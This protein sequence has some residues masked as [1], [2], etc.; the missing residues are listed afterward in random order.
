MKSRLLITAAF[1]AAL[2]L[3]G[4]GAGATY[5]SFSETDYRIEGNAANPDGG[6]RPIV[7]YRDGPKMRLETTTSAGAPAVIVFDR[8]AGNAYVLDAVALTAVAAPADAPAPPEAPWAALGAENAERVGDCTIA[9]EDGNEWRAEDQPE[10]NVACITGDGI[11]L[12][13]REG[14]QVIFEATSVQRGA[15]D[16]NLFGVPAGYQVVDPQAVLAEV[17]ETMDQMDSVTPDSAPTTTTTTAP[18]ATTPRQP[19]PTQPT[20]PAPTQPKQ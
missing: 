13:I 8:A 10:G 9:G 4:C 17:G 11:V 15:Q 20:T 16:A 14:E 18:P 3:A 2:T 6:M 12:R 7:I 1:A 5:P 19:A